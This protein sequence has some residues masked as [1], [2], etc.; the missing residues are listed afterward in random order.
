MRWC[1]RPGCDFCAENVGQSGNEVQCPCGFLFCFKCGGPGHRPCNCKQVETW[2][3]KNKDESENVTWILANTKPCTKCTKP[4]EKNQ[5]CNHM[6][7]RQ[8]G[9]EFCW[10]C[11]K[12]WKEHGTS[13]GGFY[14]CNIYDKMVAEGSDIISEEQKRLAAKNDLER[15]MFFFERYNCHNNGE[16]KA[17]EMKPMI[18]DQ[19]S[20]ISNTLFWPEGQFEFISEA[21]EQVMNVRR[22][23]KWTF[24]FAY[25]IKDEVEKKLFEHQQGELEEHCEKLHEKIEKDFLFLIEGKEEEESKEPQVERSPEE[26][27][28]QAKEETLEKSRKLRE[29]TKGADIRH[30]EDDYLKVQEDFK[31]IKRPASERKHLE[32]KPRPKPK[33]PAQVEQLKTDF[34]NFKVELLNYFKATKQYSQNLIFDVEH[35]MILSSI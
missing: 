8:C 22:M 6:T 18:K 23:L 1:P 24:T 34:L 30:F 21:L 13:T 27:K 5:G 33:S 32:E 12:D 7:C 15:Y 14:K 9:H 26:I 28:K 3:K 16:K 31:N 35:G 29:M 11:M 10:M 17:K 4:I 2:N 20:K 25:F 19:I